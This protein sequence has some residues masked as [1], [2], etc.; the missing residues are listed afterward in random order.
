MEKNNKRH[1]IHYSFE[2]PSTPILKCIECIA[3]MVTGLGYLGV[4]YIKRVATFLPR[5]G[6]EFLSS[7]TCEKICEAEGVLEDSNLD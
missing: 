3:Y 7:K 6:I 2:E 5:R 1:K 4:D